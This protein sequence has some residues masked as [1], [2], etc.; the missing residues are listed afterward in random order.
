MNAAASATWHNGQRVDA[1]PSLAVDNRGLAYGDG[2]FETMAVRDG[3][4][5]LRERHLA[6]L[7]TGLARFGI[8]APPADALAA[9]LGEAAAGNA[10]ACLKLIVTRGAGSRGYTP[11]TDAPTEWLLQRLPW[12]PPRQDRPPAAL[13]TSSVRLAL[14]PLLAGL[15][16]LNRLEQVLA[17][18]EFPAPA[19]DEV[20]QLDAEGRVACASAA[21]V[22]CLRD[23]RLRTPRVDR[24]GVAG[25]LRAEVLALS[26]SGVLPPATEA[27]LVPDDVYGADEVFLTS[28]LR[29]AWPVAALD[30]RPLSQG[31]LASRIMALWWPTG[32][33]GHGS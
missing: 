16:H 1:L 6:R 4:V 20:L 3:R 8:A 9:T 23:G 2:L 33:G 10:A 17:R 25:V 13:R 14:Q 19:H 26:A 29:G 24:C 5:L 30:G 31:G 15:K 7:A 21:N 32:E 27:D 11:A 28:S 18:R 22:F 12:S